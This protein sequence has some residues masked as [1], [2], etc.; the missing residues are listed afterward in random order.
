MLSISFYEVF[1]PGTWVPGGWIEGLPDGR[2]IRHYDDNEDNTHVRV[3][4]KKGLI[5]LSDESGDSEWTEYNT[6]EYTQLEIKYDTA[7]ITIMFAKRI[8]D[9]DD[10]H[11]DLYGAVY[12]YSA[13]II[14]Q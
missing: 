7:K 9:T 4:P 3:I 2:G 14:I 12:E 8:T 11:V 13:L 6:S 10:V 5:Q 1:E